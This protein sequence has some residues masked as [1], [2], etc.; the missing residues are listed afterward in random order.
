MRISKSWLFSHDQTGRL[1]YEWVQL[2]YSDLGNLLNLDLYSFFDLVSNIS[3]MEDNPD[4]ELVARP[5]ILFKH[6]EALD[7][8]K[9]ALLIASW[10]HGQRP[11]IPFR[12][13]AI[14]EDPENPKTPHHV[15]TQAYISPGPGEPR[16]WLNLDPTY[17]EYK[18][19]EG[20]P[21]ALYAEELLP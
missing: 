6:F 21:L 20:K 19:F 4:I 2:Y 12:F 14:S 15:L 9:K 3:F 17:S 18:I 5:E 8:K 13:V 10:L 16:D 11:S 7:C 1:M